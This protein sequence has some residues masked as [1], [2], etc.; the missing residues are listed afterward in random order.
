[1]KKWKMLVCV[2]AM[3]PAVPFAKAD[4]VSS[5]GG[6]GIGAQYWNMSDLSDVYDGGGMWGGAFTIRLR[7]LKYIG[8]DLRTGFMWT[9]CDYLKLCDRYA[10]DDRLW[11]VPLEAGV[12]VTYPIGDVLMLYGG[13]GVGYYIYGESAEI[14]EQVGQR[15][16]WTD[17]DIELENDVGWFAVAG[18]NLRLGEGASLVVEGRYTS[19]Q[20]ALKHPEE[21]TDG[22]NS[23]GDSDA[24]G[25]GAQIGFMFGY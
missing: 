15:R 6:F 25:F 11:N 10:K 22:N 13:G 16:V 3:L 4:Y 21:Y 1:M 20:I 17:T 18:I 5:G 8:V 2:L 9:Q 14:L 19:T 24:S 12:V 7:P 23:Y